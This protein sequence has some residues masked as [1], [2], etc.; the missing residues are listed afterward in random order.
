M[1]LTSVTSEPVMTW[2]FASQ[3]QLVQSYTS[4]QFPSDVKNEFSLLGNLPQKNNNSSCTSSLT[5][6]SCVYS[7]F[8]TVCKHSSLNT[9]ALPSYSWKT[10]RKHNKATLLQIFIS[11]IRINTAPK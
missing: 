10:E 1:T 5:G 7:K 3:S 9:E 11:H 2:V 4:P 6:F 8:Y